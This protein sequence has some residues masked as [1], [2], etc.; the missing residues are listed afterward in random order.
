VKK[1]LFVFLKISFS[2]ALIAWLLHRI[3]AGNVIRSLS[4]VQPGWL[5]LALAVFTLSHTLG[6]EQWRMLLTSQG[7]KI[8]FGRTLRFYFTGLFFN[9]VLISG[10]GG[11]VFRVIDVRR[12]SN[13]GAA[14]V[15]TVLLD[16]LAGLF[17]GSGFVFA[18]GPWIAFGRIWGSRMR[19]VSLALAVVW[20]LAIIVLFHR[21][22]ARPFSWLI[23][24]VMPSGMTVKIRRV[25]DLL[26]E[27]GKN[28]RLMARVLGVSVVVQSLRII[29]HFF[30]ARAFGATISMWPFFLVIPMIAIISSLPITIGGLGLREQSGVLLFAHFGLAATLAFSIELM[31]FWVTVASSLPG[32]VFFILDKREDR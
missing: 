26:H 27:F 9:N 17:V 4:T 23:H 25:Y 15:S 18:A 3:G 10:F 32:V 2:L 28:G 13:N 19:L 5:A 29:T 7:V 11:D 16:R 14:A 30:I 31:A 6:A 20:A 1:Y 12:H 24:R 22:T 21:K 8:S